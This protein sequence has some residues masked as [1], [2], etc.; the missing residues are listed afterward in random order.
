MGYFFKGSLRIPADSPDYY[1]SSGAL[2]RAGFFSEI[3]SRAE[4]LKRLN[5]AASQLPIGAEV[6]IERI[7]RMVRGYEPGKPRPGSVDQEQRLVLVDRGSW[8][9]PKTGKPRPPKWRK[10][11]ESE[12]D[13]T[14]SRRSVRGGMRS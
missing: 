10:K 3:K 1:S 14:R 11:A 7:Y 8:Y 13:R 5:S 12:R 2:S 4:L 6:T 9:D